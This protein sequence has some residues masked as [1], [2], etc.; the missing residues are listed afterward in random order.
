MNNKENDEL[1]KVDEFNVGKNID[2]NFMKNETLVKNS[3]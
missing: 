3:I 2:L 1:L